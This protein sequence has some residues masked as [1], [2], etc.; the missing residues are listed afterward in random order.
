MQMHM[1]HCPFACLVCLLLP[2]YSHVEFS[3]RTREARTAAQR[4]NTGEKPTEGEKPQFH[5][6]LDVTRCDSMWLVIQDPTIRYNSPLKHQ[7]FWQQPVW[8]NW[9]ATRSL[10]M[11]VW[12]SAKVMLIHGPL[13]LRFSLTF[14]SPRFFPCS[15]VL[16]DFS[17]WKTCETLH[18]VAITAALLSLL[19]LVTLVLVMIHGMVG[20]N[21]SNTTW[22]GSAMSNAGADA[23]LLQVAFQTE[24]SENEERQRPSVPL[25]RAKSSPVIGGTWVPCSHWQTVFLMFFPL[26]PS[27]HT[28]FESSSNIY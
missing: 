1:S 24:R 4:T 9:V 28:V 13:K 27:F 20:S 5:D 12:V 15:L 26:F 25:S 18:A 8:E 23:A 10:V 6:W 16:E 7:R 17:F 2:I 14:L 19:S 11:L 21:E 3:E 22:D